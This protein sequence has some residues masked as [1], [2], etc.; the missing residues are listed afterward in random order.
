M[1]EINELEGLG[2]WLI[3]RGIGSPVLS[4]RSHAI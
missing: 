3:L 4:N 2:G 1:S